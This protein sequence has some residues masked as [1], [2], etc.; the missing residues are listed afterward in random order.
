M[1]ESE[2]SDEELMAAERA[3]APVSSK[4]AKLLGMGDSRTPSSSIGNAG[5]SGA[6]TY[7]PAIIRPR[8]ASGSVMPTHGVTIVP[9]SLPIA[10]GLPQHLRQEP[11]EEAAAQA[12]AG[13][14]A[15]KNAESGLSRSLKSGGAAGRNVL[16]LAAPR[17]ASY[18][19]SDDESGPSSSRALD[20]DNPVIPPHTLVDK[21]TFHVGSFKKRPAAET[22]AGSLGMRVTHLATEGDSGPMAISP[23]AAERPSMPAMSSSLP[24]ISGPLGARHL[25]QP[26][27][28]ATGGSSSSSSSSSSSQRLGFGAHTS[29]PPKAAPNQSRGALP[30]SRNPTAQ[31]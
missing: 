27:L 21:P 31:R 5:Q 30:S 13:N 19:S 25:V 1:G 6:A 10:I 15:A 11:G 3:R 22:M 23:L 12:D 18:S 26:A 29:A 8:T 16:S 17:F 7:T 28:P 2:L 4:A 20:D 14:N 9:M 24:R